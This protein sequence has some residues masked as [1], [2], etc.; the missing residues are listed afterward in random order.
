M[1]LQKPQGIKYHEA[2]RRAQR[3]NHQ[4]VKAMG[5]DEVFAL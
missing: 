4:E 2:K 5:A 1:R 3:S